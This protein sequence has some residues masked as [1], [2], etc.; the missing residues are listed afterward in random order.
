MFFLFNW[1][2]FPLLQQ[3]LA[4]KRLGK[5]GKAAKISKITFACC[6]TCLFFFMRGT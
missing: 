4:R 1:L 3:M 2:S 6:S 5:N